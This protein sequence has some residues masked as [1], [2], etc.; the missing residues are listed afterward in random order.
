MFVKTRGLVLRVSNYNDTDALLTLLTENHGKLTVKV[1]GLK[2]KNS[3][4]F[5]PSQLLA[6]SEFTLFENRGLYTVNEAESIELFHSLRTDLEKLSLGT[7][8]VQAAEVVCQE[9]I[10]NPQLLPLLLN[11]LYALTKLSVNQSIV[12]AV[13]EL[14]VACLA[15]YTPDLSS[16]C[17]CGNAFPDRFN[18]SLGQLE[19]FACSMH[20]DNGIRMPLN[21]SALDTLRY[22]CYCDPKK[23]FSFRIG[24]D[25]LQSI[26]QIAEGYLLT[27]L[28]RGFSA[29]DFYK[30][31][32]I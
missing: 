4:L 20:T 9:D 25:T 16:C 23:I 12:K 15:G 5:A 13:F 18:L 14:R 8:F 7:Y 28:E 32:L 30:T 26:V 19:C 3:P 2:R 17:H 27:Q 24:E 10:P 11:C 31:L 22:I 21:T 1:R 29:L 6:Y